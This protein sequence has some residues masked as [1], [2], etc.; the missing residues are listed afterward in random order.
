MHSEQ[1]ELVDAALR[2]ASGAFERVAC[3]AQMLMLP[4]NSRI[5]LDLCLEL[6]YGV[7]DADIQSYGL[8]SESLDEEFYPG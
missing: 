5:L 1:C 4:R 3:E 7:V 6:V 8:A 2:R